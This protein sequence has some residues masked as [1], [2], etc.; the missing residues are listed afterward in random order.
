M[1]AGPEFIALVRQSIL[2]KLKTLDI[3]S[4]LHEEYL[5][6]N[7]KLQIVL[8]SCEADAPS[9]E[10]KYWAEILEVEQ[11]HVLN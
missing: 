5:R 11:C 7:E 3:S 10:R 1:T 6:L 8:E 4:S 2:S 9:L